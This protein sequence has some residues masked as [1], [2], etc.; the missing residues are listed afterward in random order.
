[1]GFFPSCG[2]VNITEWMHHTDAHKIYGENAIWKLHNIIA[3]SA[4]AVEYTDGTS[5]EG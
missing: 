5:V 4:G 1:M 2:C 3:Q